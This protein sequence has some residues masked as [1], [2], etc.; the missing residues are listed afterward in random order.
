MPQDVMMIEGRN[1]AFVSLFRGIIRCECGNQ[2]FRAAVDPG[3][4]V[5][6]LVCDRCG[7]A[8]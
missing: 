4:Q 6:E 2:T 5:A 3:L 7:Q 8:L 1:L